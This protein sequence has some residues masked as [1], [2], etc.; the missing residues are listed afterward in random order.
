VTASAAVLLLATAVAAVADWV[1]VQRST[2]VLEYAAKPL[3]MVGL[4]AVALAVRPVNPGQRGLFVVALALGLASDVFLMLPRDMF[5]A[6]LVAALVE[7]IAYIAGFLTRGF[8]PLGFAFALAVALVSVATFLPPIYRAVRGS[9]PALAVPV[10]AYV[11]VF[12]VMVAAAGASGSLVA[13]AGALLFFYSDAI[14]AWNRFVRPLPHGRLFN[15]VPY[16]VGEALLVLSL[17]F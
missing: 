14:L 9:A 12:V 8:H 11:A 1:A 4:I 6:G 2:L 5:L 17:V 16:H 7:H 3:V 13:L 15:I 10:L